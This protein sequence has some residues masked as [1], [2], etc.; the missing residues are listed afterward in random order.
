MQN[1]PNGCA[2]NE[3]VLQHG[4]RAV[5]MENDVADGGLTAK[6]E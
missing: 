4:N 6:G 2:I 1:S 5:T 3:I